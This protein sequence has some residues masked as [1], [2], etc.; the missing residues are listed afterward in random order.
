MQALD[1][2]GHVRLSLLYRTVRLY[3][4]HRA[5][6]RPSNEFEQIPIA[7]Q[8]ALHTRQGALKIQLKVEF[9][10]AHR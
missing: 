1:A 6:D 8:E 4:P 2:R 3:E 10:L 7:C 9:R 5:M